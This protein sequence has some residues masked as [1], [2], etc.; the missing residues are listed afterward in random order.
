[1]QAE[2]RRVRDDPNQAG[3]DHNEAD[4]HEPGHPLVRGDPVVDKA[5]AGDGSD[6]GSHW[7]TARAQA[8]VRETRLLLGMQPSSGTSALRS[9]AFAVRFSVSR[10]STTVGPAQFVPNETVT[11]S[12]APSSA[13]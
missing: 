10:K 6:R 5:R 1:P 13:S 2:A 8:V 3:Q 12:R 9:S 11:S 4:H 7:M